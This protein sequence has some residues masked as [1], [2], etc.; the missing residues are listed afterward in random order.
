[1]TPAARIM[2]SEP[3][4]QIVADWVAGSHGHAAGGCN[5]AAQPEH[6]RC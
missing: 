4:D 5:S 3:K 2:V 6:D 1:M